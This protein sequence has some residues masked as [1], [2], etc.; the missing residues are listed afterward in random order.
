[1]IQD[2]Q[3][4]STNMCFIFSGE[5]TVG[6]TKTLNNF[7]KQFANITS[8]LFSAATVNATK[9]PT[10]INFVESINKP[11]YILDNIYTEY[12]T[13]DE[14]IK[15]YN[16]ATQ[17]ALNLTL[18]TSITL[19]FPTTNQVVHNV[20][21]IDMP[22]VNL[23]NKEEYNKMQ[24]SLMELYPRHCIL[25][26]IK[27]L[28][29]ETF[30][31]LKNTVTILT[32]A[33]VIN[34]KTDE[35]MKNK[36][37]LFMQH[38]SSGKILYLS[39]IANHTGINLD[40]TEIIVYNQSTFIELFSKCLLFVNE[41]QQLDIANLKDD[42]EL[43]N[44]IL[45]KEELI[46]HVKKYNNKQLHAAYHEHLSQ[47]ISS[48][49]IHNIFNDFEMHHAQMQGGPTTIL[50]SVKHMLLRNLCNYAD[51]IRTVID[52]EYLITSNKRCWRKVL[53][54]IRSEIL[55]KNKIMLRETKEKIITGCLNLLC[56]NNRKRTRD[57]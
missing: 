52:E 26:I 6:K 53:N 46:D 35:T 11:S 33:D 25:N 8:E 34:Y 45:T 9:I 28:N 22:G 18:N 15:W 41:I 57:M 17:N 14:L 10:I 19:N 29:V 30:K 49:E 56:A 50:K 47:Y 23:N 36:H 38:I 2:N 24:N 51:I 54:K 5:T 43:I 55:E 31:E 4:Y 21:I 3:L 16:Q 12:A 39:N 48:F 40:E 13:I 27:D 1:M 32:H 42:A 7:I 20:T 37:K 44:I